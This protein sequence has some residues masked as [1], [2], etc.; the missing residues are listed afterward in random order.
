MPILMRFFEKNT[1]PDLWEKAKLEEEFTQELDMTF[2]KL[3]RE[4]EQERKLKEDEQKLR[5]EEQKL[6]EIEQKLREEERKLKEE[7]YLE[8][9]RLKALIDPNM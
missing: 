7:A 6:R 5:E 9:E 1:T 4:V 3:M 8:I 2:A